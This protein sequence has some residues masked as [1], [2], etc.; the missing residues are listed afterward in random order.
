MSIGL[1]NLFFLDSTDNQRPDIGVV[2][3]FRQR[4]PFI[5]G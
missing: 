2:G 4:C 1:R 5:R 3:K